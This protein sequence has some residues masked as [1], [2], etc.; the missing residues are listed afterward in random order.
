MRCR[1]VPAFVAV[2]LVAAATACAG[3]GGD[4]AG[5]S[6][7]RKPVVLKLESEDDLT[8]S[9]APEFAEVV[10]RLSGGSLRIEFLQAGRGLE[11][12]FEEGVVEDVRRGKAQL[13]IVGVRV[14]DTIG[15]RSFQALLAPFLVDS[16]ELERRVL[17]SPLAA[18]M[19]DGVE[20]AGVVGIALLPGPL[21]R[22]FGLSLALAGPEDYRGATVGIRPGAVAQATLRALAA[23]GK[24]YVPG[25][26]SGLDAV[27]IDPKTIAYNGWEGTLTT[28]VVLWPKP[29]SI[30]MNRRAYEALTAEQQELLRRAGREALAPELR[31]TVRDAAAGLAEA[32]GLGGLSLATASAGDRAAL[33]AAVQ[34]GYDELERDPRTKE[35]IGA[36]VD[37]RGNAPTAT[38][39]RRCRPVGGSVNDDARPLGGRWTYTWKRAELLAAGIAERFIPP[40]VQTATVIFEFAGGRYR[41]IAGGRVRASGTYTVEGDVMRLVHDAPASPGYVAGQVYQQRWSIYRDVLE[42]RRVPGSDA[43]LVLLVKPLTRVR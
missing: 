6:A 20:R 33:R 28:N 37:M 17:E 1:A 12:N 42:F 13:G 22:P 19:L 4:K 21:R 16:Y 15:V 3:S 31:Q 9:G 39:P 2:A 8:L 5:G 14:W 27:E 40:G 24:G 26:L 32:C 36:I 38:T 23:A 29:Y 30:V 10:A 41:A 43:D 18:D 34:P 7:D 11:V 35:L 25:S